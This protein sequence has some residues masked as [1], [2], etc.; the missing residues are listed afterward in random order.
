VLHPQKFSSKK[1][2]SCSNS[3]LVYSTDGGR[4]IEYQIVPLAMATR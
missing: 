1:M 3:G 4:M 2:K